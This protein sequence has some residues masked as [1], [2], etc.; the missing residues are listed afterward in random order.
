MPGIDFLVERSIITSDAGIGYTVRST[1]PA[2][3]EVV[4]GVE[5]SRERGLLAYRISRMLPGE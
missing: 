3:M 4:L 2:S 1:G 5:I